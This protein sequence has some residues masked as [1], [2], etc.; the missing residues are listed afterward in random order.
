MA[1][2]RTRV[3]ISFEDA[4]GNGGAMSFILLP[5]LSSSGILSFLDTVTPILASLTDA[6]IVSATSYQRYEFDTPNTA[7][8]DADLNTK[9]ALF[10]RNEEGTEGIYVPAPKEYLFTSEGPYAGIRLNIP[11]AEIDA[12][13]A[14]LVAFPG[15]L[16][17]AEGE[18]FPLTFWIGGKML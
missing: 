5:S 8:A 3:R 4:D 11:S 6:S 10:Y 1:M 17:T 15:P 16:A 7:T 18:P 14:A 9:L 12:L 13:N 2:L